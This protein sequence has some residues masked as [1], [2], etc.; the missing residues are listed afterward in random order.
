MTWLQIN[1]PS[2][3]V[4]HTRGVKFFDFG[5]TL[6]ALQKQDAEFHEKGTVS[7][8]MLAPEEHWEAQAEGTAESKALLQRAVAPTPVPSEQ[9]AAEDDIP[10]LHEVGGVEF[11]VLSWAVVVRCGTHCALCHRRLEMWR[12]DV[13]SAVTPRGLG[14]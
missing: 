2:V 1:A 10:G 12:G 9:K 6:K 8:R 7:L 11:N 4:V 14:C 5:A 3:D 13:V